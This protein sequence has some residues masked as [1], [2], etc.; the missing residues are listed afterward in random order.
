[1]K[2]GKGTY[3]THITDGKAAEGGVVGKGFDAHGLGGDHLDDSGIAG[4]DELG[5]VLDRLA[6]AAID[7]LEELGKFAGNVGSVTVEDWSIASTDLARV[8]EDDD[9][10][11]ERLGALGRVVLRLTS[12]VASAD[13]LDGDVLDV[14]ADVVTRK[15]SFCELL[16]VHL[17]RLDFGCNTSGSK[18]HDHTGLDF[19][20]L[21]TSD[22]YSA[23]TSN[24]V[25]ILEWKTKRL[26]SGS[27]WGFD[28]INGF[29]KSLASNLGLAVLLPALVPRAVGRDIDHVVAVEARNGDEWN[30]LG[31][32]ANL[33][34]EG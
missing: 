19:A 33:L 18:G 31:V 4:L 15:A 2:E 1:M 24:L 23:N 9:L 25:D 6:G 17:D 20:S 5:G 34:D 30:G 29:E 21:D 8:V 28:G 32:E 13:F 16:M 14:E 27:A 7:L 3:L 22:W 26:V 11:V 10:G 12:D